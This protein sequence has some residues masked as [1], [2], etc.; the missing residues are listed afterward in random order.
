MPHPPRRA[1]L[2]FDQHVHVSSSE[3]R[4]VPQAHDARVVLRRVAQLVRQQGAAALRDFL[5]E[6]GVAL[7]R[8][9]LYKVVV[10]RP[11]RPS[12]PFP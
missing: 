4:D 3:P 6:V 5:P 7:L 8:F 2:L 10:R 12:N 11:T 9:N 1:L